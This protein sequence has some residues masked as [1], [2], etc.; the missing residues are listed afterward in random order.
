MYAA[1]TPRSRNTGFN[2]PLIAQHSARPSPPSESSP[3]SCGYSNWPVFLHVLP[4]TF[5][6]I[7]NSQR[8]CSTG[9]LRHLGVTV[10][11][12]GAAMASTLRPLAQ[13]DTPRSVPGCPPPSSHLSDYAGTTL[14]RCQLFSED[15]IR[16]FERRCDF[17]TPAGPG[18]GRAGYQF[19]LRLR[20]Q[21]SWPKCPP[22]A[23]GNAIQPHMC[24][25]RLVDCGEDMPTSACIPGIARTP[26]QTLPRQ[27]PRHTSVTVTGSSAPVAPE[28]DR[29]WE[30][31]VRELE[32][33]ALP[34][35]F[36]QIIVA[37]GKRAMSFGFR[38]PA[39]TVGW[40]GC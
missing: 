39:F 37:D 6:A 1:A 22:P 36:K 10:C 32:R 7:R 13:F 3:G 35:N 5:L 19:R 27:R 12:F 29:K 17:P 21:L 30:V 18:H 16:L 23:I 33:Y 25:L 34:S 8:P 20:A 28:W 15:D 24:A 14:G 38:E 2:L 31:I 9:P 11:T 40:H 26:I 4:Q